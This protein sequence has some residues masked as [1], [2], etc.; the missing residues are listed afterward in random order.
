V[1]SDAPLAAAL[2]VVGSC[3]GFAKNV[4]IFIDKATV[5]VFTNHSEST[6]AGN[7][8]VDSNTIVRQTYFF[9][10]TLN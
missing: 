4:K 3:P 2:P 6:L 10:L 8:A 1:S 7:E 9:V 5:L